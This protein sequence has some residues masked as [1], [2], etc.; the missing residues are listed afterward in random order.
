[1]IQL[2]TYLGTVVVEGPSVPKISGEGGGS[3][4]NGE[5]HRDPSVK[6]SQS[7]AVGHFSGTHHTMAQN[8][9]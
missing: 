3:R 5:E 2:S 9:S 7:P 4:S 8:G 1:M 6:Q